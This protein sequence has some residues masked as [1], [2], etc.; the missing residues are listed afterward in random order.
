[1]LENP[2]LDNKSTVE[3]A[4]IVDASKVILYQLSKRNKWVLKKLKGERSLSLKCAHGMGEDV[5]RF[6]E[7]VN[8]ELNLK[9]NLLNVSIKIIY[10]DISI[11]TVGNIIHK[12][13]ERQC[14]SVDVLSASYL[15]GWIGGNQKV[16]CFTNDKWLEERLL[17]MLKSNNVSTANDYLVCD[18]EGSVQAQEE[19]VQRYEEE[20]SKLKI[21]TK[22]LENEISTYSERDMEFLISFMPVLYEGFWDSISPSDF[23]LINGKVTV[24]V[25]KSP[26]LEP[27]K[28]TISSLKRKFKKLDKLDQIKIFELC[29][30][31]PTTTIMRKEMRPLYEEYLNDV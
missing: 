2:E 16:D 13:S 18:T 30:D 23:A 22:Q 10:K 5:G 28:N 25:V 7:E 31:I 17:P 1:M 12:L 24:P 3:L 14:N 6:V 29:K 20:L 21:K 26:Y 4:I 11:V 9:D 15:L 27:S 19:K 8:E